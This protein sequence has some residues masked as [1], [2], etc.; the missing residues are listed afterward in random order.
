MLGA[1]TDT[2]IKI[3]VRSDVQAT[4]VVEYQLADGNWS[5]PLQSSSVTLIATNDFTGIISILNLASST[6]YD[7]RVLLDGVIQQGSVSKLK[8]L[9]AIGF[10]SKIKFAFGSDILEDQKPFDVFYQV[11]LHNPDLMLFLGDNM[12]LDQPEQL[13]PGFESNFWI[14]YK[15]NRDAAYQAFANHT[16]IFAIWDNHDYGG[17]DPD[18]YYEYKTQSRAAFGKYWPNPTYV[19]Q[20]ASIYYKFRAGDAEFFALDNRWNMVHGVTMLGA[21]QLTWLK[22]SLLSST[23]KFKFILSPVTFSDF[24][25]AGYDTWRGFPAERTDIVNFITQ[26]NIKNVVFLTGDQHWT[27]VFLLDYPVNQISQN[28]RGF[29][30]F[31]PSPLSASPIPAVESADLQILFKDNLTYHYYGVVTVDSTRIPAQAYFEIYRGN[32]ELLYSISIPEF[33]PLTSPIIS[34]AVVADGYVGQPYSQPLEKTVGG[35]APFLWSLTSGFLPPGLSLSTGGVIA[36]TPSQLGV[37]NFSVQLQD[38]ALRVATANLS[39][40]VTPP[41]PPPPPPYALSISSPSVQP[42]VP[43]STTWSAPAGSGAK[44]WVALFGVGNSN[45]VAWTYTNGAMSGTFIT[46]AP[47]PGQYEFRYSNNSPTYVATSAPITV[48]A[49]PTIVT[50]SLAGGNV[51]Q[52]YSQTLQLSGGTTPFLWSI[53]TGALTPG[54]ELKPRWSHCRHPVTT[55]CV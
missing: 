39:I 13:I 12:Y 53:T 16:P 17:T 28:V 19:E 44:N 42:G 18:K 30:E 6:T 41:P 24:A 43:I 55:W 5:Q 36:G 34:S 20:D 37:F 4:A 29:Y 45:Y 47:A 38:S 31:M 14:K 54:S 7:Y 40:K 8:T 50:S 2:S 32:N 27:G 1:V 48:S 22:N 51:Q 11:G 21:A 35:T 33:T 25:T 26:T 23:A 15:G 52:P 49:P 9:P 10:P 46:T 3:W